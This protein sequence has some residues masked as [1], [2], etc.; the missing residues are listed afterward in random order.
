[1]ESAGRGYFVSELAELQSNVRSFTFDEDHLISNFLRLMTV[2][3][4][5]RLTERNEQ[6]RLVTGLPI[7][8]NKRHRDEVSSC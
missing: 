3:A 7:S 2:I 4:L 8:Y 5:S 1:V 6:V